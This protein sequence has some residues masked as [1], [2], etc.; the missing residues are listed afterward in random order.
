MRSR[1]T[2]AM[3]GIAGGM[4]LQ[5]QGQV[6]GEDATAVVADLDQRRTSC[7]HLHAHPPRTGVQAVLE[8]LLEHR[9]R[10][11]HHLAGGDLVRQGRVQQPDAPARGVARGRNAHATRP[12]TASDS[13]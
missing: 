9:R 8:Q 7:G 6:L 12:K 5:G 11:L 3:L 1:D 10:S 13:T 2:D 4:A